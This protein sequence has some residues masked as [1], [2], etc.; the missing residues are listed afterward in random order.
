[1]KALAILNR[2][3]PK[4]GG[5]KSVR[6]G[7]GWGYVA[8]DGSTAVVCSAMVSTHPDDMDGHCRSELWVYHNDKPPELITY[9]P[10]EVAP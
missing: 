4:P 10:V 1:M 8:S 6:H 3:S 7:F 2:E 9:G 5:W